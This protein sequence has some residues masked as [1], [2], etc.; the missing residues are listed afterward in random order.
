MSV[1]A[2]RDRN[3]ERDPQVNS[4]MKNSLLTGRNLEQDQAR[5]AKPAPRRLSKG[6]KEEGARTERIKIKRQ[7]SQNKTNIQT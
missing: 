2:F 4:G 1:G 5:R 3:P 6:E 7:I